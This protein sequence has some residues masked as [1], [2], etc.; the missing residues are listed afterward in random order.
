[1]SGGFF[2]Y[3]HRKDVEELRSRPNRDNLQQLIGF[4]RVEEYDA[5]AEEFEQFYRAV[6]NSSK[7]VDWSDAHGGDESSEAAPGLEYWWNQLKWVAKAAEWWASGDTGERRFRES[8]SEYLQD[9][10]QFYGEN[11][12]GSES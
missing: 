6:Q 10:S 1:M 8:W 9:M 2:D 3:I 12:G 5:A 7:S 11:G 4:L